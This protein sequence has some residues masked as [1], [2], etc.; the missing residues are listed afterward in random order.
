[1]WGL[2]LGVSC[3]NGTAQVGA[4]FPPT[5]DDMLAW[6]SAAELSSDVKNPNRPLAFCCMKVQAG[7]AY[8]MQDSRA[9]RRACVLAHFSRLNAGT[10]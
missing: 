5:H 8:M 2:H 7:N 9:S 6:N 10:L 3:M 4:P 1:M